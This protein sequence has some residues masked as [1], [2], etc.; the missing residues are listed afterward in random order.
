M[1][2]RFY[3]VWTDHSAYS[4]AF[5]M[6]IC[7]C[8]FLHF[9][10]CFIAYITF[11]IFKQ[12]NKKDVVSTYLHYIDTL[13][14]IPLW[15]A[16]V[17]LTRITPFYFTVSLSHFVCVPAEITFAFSKHQNK[18]VVSNNYYCIQVPIH[19][20]F[21]CV[22]LFQHGTAWFVFLMCY[23]L[24]DI[25]YI[26][27]VCHL[28]DTISIL[29]VLLHIWCILPFRNILVYLTSFYQMMHAFH[30]LKWFC[31]L[32]WYDCVDHSTPMWNHPSL[33]YI[34]L[35][36]SQVA[37]LS[38]L[39]IL[40]MIHQVNYSILKYMV[41]SVKNVSANHYLAWWR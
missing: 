14:F 3:S 10:L 33:T 2:R 29:Y 41:T 34:M 28:L 26:Y 9:L 7:S 23:Y 4:P 8:L 13:L 38:V 25:L 20:L 15:C 18:D 19:R 17:K 27:D 37:N 36:V 22:C 31:M 1:E 35:V 40:H 16:S 12:H 11:T 6:A 32:S 39:I 5:V 21:I 24:L 30:R